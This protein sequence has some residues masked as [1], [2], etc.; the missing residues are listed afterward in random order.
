MRL[1]QIEIE[2]FKGVGEK[3][4]LDLAPITLL[5]GPNSAGKSTILQAL[6][7]VRAILEGEN[8][9]PD[10]YVD[11]GDVDYG[12]FKN[13]V[14]GHDLSKEIYIGLTIDL[15]DDGGSSFF[16]Y[17]LGDAIDDVQFRELQVQY[18]AGGP[19]QIKTIGVGF[20]VRWRELTNAPVLSTLSIKFNRESIGEIQSDGIGRNIDNINLK[21]PLLE[22]AIDLA[23][24]ADDD[25]D[26][27]YPQDGSAEAEI[28][29]DDPSF[30]PLWRVY[31]ENWEKDLQ[32]DGILVSGYSE[33]SGIRGAIRHLD[34]PLSIPFKRD[35]DE[36]IPEFIELRRP[37]N[38]AF[39]AMG[40]VS[41][42][43]DL[44]LGPVRAVREL[45]RE[46]CHIG[47]IRE[48]PDSTYQPSR[49][50]SPWFRGRAAWDLLYDPNSNELL[51]N[52]NHWISGEDRLDTGYEIVDRTIREVPVPSAFDQFFE[53]NLEEDDLPQLKELYA[54][55]KVVREIRLRDLK[56][57]IDVFP[58]D[59]GVGISQLIPVVVA[60]C[61]DRLGLI[62][63]EQ[64]ELH[65]H[66]R[67][68]VQ[69][70]DL[71]IDRTAENAQ[72]TV[73]METHSEHMLLR[74]LRRIAETTEG[75]LPPGASSLDRFDLSVIYV[76][77]TEEGVQF[78][79]L[80]VNPDGEFRDRW[81]E[82]FF[83]ER[84]DELF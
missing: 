10:P 28:D 60:C 43:D 39:E 58:F 78:K 69:L 66:P 25:D 32:T 23:L 34:A 37:H 24:V 31:W 55:L 71:L 22:Q 46:S 40:L 27:I 33:H 20:K 56:N 17:S 8:P 5:F 62:A 38:A 42:L 9:D 26:G 29:D 53:R 6:Q 4:T 2:N 11:S 83:G 15:T 73:L 48:I 30:S 1:T 84:A 50:L 70:G 76:Q 52:V 61:F 47:P 81:P 13:L 59:V 12:G 51:Q 16:R 19:G 35:F 3:Q 49:R 41:L 7:Y 36:F 54:S 44:F 82:G 57:N 18:L 21:H 14:H 72:K 45:L 67:I 74:M 63:V 79:K 68:Q 77:P 65:L 64:P 80:R 75:E